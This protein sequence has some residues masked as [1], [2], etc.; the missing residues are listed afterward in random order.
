MPRTVCT[1]VFI[2]W[3]SWLF[4]PDSDNKMASTNLIKITLLNRGKIKRLLKSR[5]AYQE[6]RIAACNQR[7]DRYARAIAFINAG[8]KE[9]DADLYFNIKE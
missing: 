5:I 2:L 4:C 3:N 9:L 8:G 1:L 6:S 7:I